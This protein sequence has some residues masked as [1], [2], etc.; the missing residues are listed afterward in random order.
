M[1]FRLQ[2]LD[3]CDKTLWEILM[4][5]IFSQILL[6]IDVSQVVNQCA[7]AIRFRMTNFH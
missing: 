6:N 1:Q 5:A 4:A 3:N 2:M 7:L